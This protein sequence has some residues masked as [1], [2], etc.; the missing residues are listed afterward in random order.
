MRP[1]R[2]RGCRPP[3]RK[4]DKFSTNPRERPDG[5]RAWITRTREVMSLIPTTALVPRVA[6]TGAARGLSASP[7][8]QI[9]ASPHLGLLRF[10]REAA[11]QGRT[12]PTRRGGLH[13]GESAESHGAVA[14]SAV[15]GQTGA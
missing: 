5:G 8:G 14:P 9:H 1:G 10:R 4:S 3:S 15:A 13:R 12:L 11:G 2:T 7:G 6:W